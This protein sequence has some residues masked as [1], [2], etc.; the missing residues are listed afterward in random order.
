[1]QPTDDSALLRR[2]AENHSNEAFA[3]L[4]T[5]HVNLVYSVALRRVGNAHQAEE[6]TQAVFIILAKKAAQL[7]HDKALAG[8]LFQA[9][10]LTANNFVRSEIRRHHREQEV[11]LQSSLNE[12]GHEIWPSLVP[13]LDA[14]VAGL[15]D[16]E[17]RGIVLRYYEGLNL[18]EVALA[19]GAIEV[20][21]EKRVS[22][23]VEKLRRHFHK[24]GVVLPAAALVV[25]ISAISVQAAPTAL[26]K[27]V[28][29]VALA[30]GAT[31]SG[32]TLTLVEGALKLMAWTKTQAA[33]IGA[34]VIGLAIF[35]VVQHQ[36]GTKL[37]EQNEA[38]RQQMVQ[39]QSD[40]K[41]LS[42]RRALT[43][44][45]PAPQMQVPAPATN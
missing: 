24:H 30:K 43:P 17:R 3:S 26:A 5:R 9:T 38:L 31:A 16:K 34:A 21:A 1:M 15:G 18:G 6:I 27:T 22:R 20:A 36:A 4:V 13:L 2:Y 28:T 23:A 45:P 29:L 25:A 42:A 12:S 37:R 10:R 44:R 33:I 14:A 7:R 41:R 40:N 39:L 19:L 32:S 8:W 35:S 11:H